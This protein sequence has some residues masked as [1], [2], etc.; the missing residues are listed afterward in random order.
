MKENWRDDIRNRLSDFETTPPKGLWEGLEK[1]LGGKTA[2]PLP[3]T[4]RRV[5]DARVW[6]PLLTAAAIA[7]ILIAAGLALLI[8]KSTDIASHPAASIASANAPQVS[9]AS[10]C[11]NL[12]ATP[13]PRSA[14]VRHGIPDPISAHDT[15]QTLAH[16]SRCEDDQQ[17]GIQPETAIE[18]EEE[19]TPDRALHHSALPDENSLPHRNDNHYSPHLRLLRNSASKLSIGLTAS[20]MS[21]A[22]MENRLPQKL[23]VDDGTNTGDLHSPDSIKLQHTLPIRAGLLL[24][25][26]LTDRLGIETGILYTHLRSQGSRNFSDFIHLFLSQNLHYLGVSLKLKWNVISWKGASAYL[27]AGLTGEKCIKNSTLCR[28]DITRGEIHLTDTVPVETPKPF[29]CTAN[30]S[31]GVQVRLWRHLA[32]FAEPGIEYHFNDGSGLRTYYS[33]HPLGFSLNLGVRFML[34]R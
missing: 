29:Q 33:E 14:H 24:E 6:R 11:G 5:A 18:N 12:A 25:Y 7:L 20:C 8:P 19:S 34:P 17:S 10:E 16:E 27:S 22:L 13:A 21:G 9:S 23:I 2:A 28:R 4:G 32:I 1:E 30:L 31:A 26:P 3:V 15:P